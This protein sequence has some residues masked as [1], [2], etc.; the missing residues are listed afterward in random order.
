MDATRMSFRDN[1]FDLSVDKGTYDA[2]AV[3]ICLYMAKNS[4]LVRAQQR[5]TEET[6]ARDGSSDL[7]GRRYHFVWNPKQESAALA[8][9]HRQ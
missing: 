8:G 7:S 2:L 3:F 6:S 9:I 1:S 5:G 4:F